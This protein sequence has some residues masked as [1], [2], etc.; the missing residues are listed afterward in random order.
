M[1]AVK[2]LKRGGFWLA[3]SVLI[4]L[5]VDKKSDSSDIALLCGDCFRSDINFTVLVE[6]E[7]LL[8]RYKVVIIIL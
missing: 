1:L 5:Q 3:V 8:K 2:G 6:L 7:R 4:I